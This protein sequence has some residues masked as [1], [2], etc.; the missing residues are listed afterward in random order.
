[1]QIK[2]F[3]YLS[4]N[5]N[6]L[7][8]AHIHRE[9]RSPHWLYINCFVLT[10]TEGWL[11]K[12]RRS[13]PAFVNWVPISDE[14]Q[15]KAETQLFQCWREILHSGAA[16]RSA[17]LSILNKA[18][19]LWVEK[20]SQC[21]IYSVY[22]SAHYVSFFFFW[23]RK[24]IKSIVLLSRAGQRTCFKMMSVN[25]HTRTRKQT[26]IIPSRC[27]YSREVCSNKLL[28]FTSDNSI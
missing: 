25:I 18:Y 20:L 26:N 10:K 16:I 23:T 15:Q 13:A 17:Q 3:S 7:W 1:M 24:V 28:H 2:L 9:G 27:G 6:P 19:L 5:K 8:Q 21:V 22:W 14:K 11:Y 4:R 12:F